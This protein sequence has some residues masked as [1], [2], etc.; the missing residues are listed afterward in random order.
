MK[1]QVIEHCPALPP[2]EEAVIEHC[3]ALPPYEEAV[4]EHCPALPPYE[5]AVSRDL[6]SQILTPRA[7][8]FSAV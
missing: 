4:I 3:P 7:V 5:E 8:F 1:G 2:Y 6:G